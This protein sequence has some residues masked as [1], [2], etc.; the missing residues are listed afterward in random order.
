MVSSYD[1]I[2]YDLSL[3]AMDIDNDDETILAYDWLDDTDNA[4]DF[5]SEY[6]SDKGGDSYVL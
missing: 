3:L 2:D 4:D 5:I 1:A 6:V